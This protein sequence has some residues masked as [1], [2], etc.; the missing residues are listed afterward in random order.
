MLI[1]DCYEK[2]EKLEKEN[3]EIKKELEDIKRTLDNAI[4]DLKELNHRRN[5][6]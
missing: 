6:F 3:I 4:N 1:E 5:L 2:V